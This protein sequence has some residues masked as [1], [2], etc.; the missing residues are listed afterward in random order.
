MNRQ[1][2]LPLHTESSSIQNNPNSKSFVTTHSCNSGEELVA[3]F[4]EHGNER[5]ISDF[6]LDS[7]TQVANKSKWKQ[8]R[9]DTYKQSKQF[10]ATGKCLE[11]RLNNLVQFIY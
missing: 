2:K 5:E 7:L 4:C 6:S 3:A 10:L 1:A 11:S 8:N 9:L